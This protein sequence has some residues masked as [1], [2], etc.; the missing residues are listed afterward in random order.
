[1]ELQHRKYFTK[2]ELWYKNPLLSQPQRLAD[3]LSSGKCFYSLKFVFFKI[4]IKDRYYDHLLWD[5][6][7]LPQVAPF[8]NMV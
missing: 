4:N 7:L 8:T 5:F 6:Y 3:S 2:F 1:M